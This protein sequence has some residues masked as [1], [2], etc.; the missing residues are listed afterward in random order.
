MSIPGQQDANT[1]KGS[2]DKAAGTI[3][4]EMTGP[5]GNADAID[6]K[7]VTNKSIF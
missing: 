4:I 7:L 6:G 3:A 2:V 1:L 5:N